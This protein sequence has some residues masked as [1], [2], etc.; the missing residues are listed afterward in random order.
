MNTLCI[1]KSW[2]GL[3]LELINVLVFLSPI[4]FLFFY[5]LSNLLTLLLLLYILLVLS[6]AV[7]VILFLRL[8][9]YLSIS[10][11][12][13]EFE[14]KAFF[15]WGLIES[16]HLAEEKETYYSAETGRGHT[17]SQKLCISLKNADLVRYPLDQ[18]AKN[19]SQIIVLLDQR[20]AFVQKWGI[21]N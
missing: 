5:D 21:F 7:Y 6:I 1:K 12:G 16:Y 15:G 14:D 18:L 11:K 10:D 9:T 4:C 3:P 8:K 17:I 13:I 2:K 19:P 20:R